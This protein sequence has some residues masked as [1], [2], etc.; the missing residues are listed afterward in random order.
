MACSG[1]K[2]AEAAFAIDL[3]QGVMYESFRTHLNLRA[4]PRILILSALHGF[5]DPYTFIQPYEQKMTPGRADHLIGAAL[6]LEQWPTGIK[7]VFMAGGA[8]YRRVML[9]A[10]RQL[11]AAGRVPADAHVAGTH[12]G[13]GYQRAQLGM[14]L[15]SLP[16]SRHLAGEHPNGTPLYQSLDGFS[17]GDDVVAKYRPVEQGEKAVIEELFYGPAGPT[18]AVSMAPEK[19]SKID[20]RRWVGL[21][22]LFLAPCVVTSIQT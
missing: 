16:T 20:C 9:A 21:K 1:A 5:I 4:R 8:E 12:G 7:R 3:Y 14:Y 19:P 22:K 2:L 11:Q 6:D 18:A 17:V 13:I 10:V 15:R